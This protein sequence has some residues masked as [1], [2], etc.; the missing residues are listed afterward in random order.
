MGIDYFNNNVK[1]EDLAPGAEYSFYNVNT[2]AAATLTIKTGSGFLGG[3]TINSHTAGII[4]ITDGT[5]FAAGNLMHSSLTFAAG[6]RSIDFRGERFT[7]GL[8][9]SIGGSAFVTV[10]YK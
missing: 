3:I 6:E 10:Q 7:T 9:I 8:T 1:N 2:G 5:T 4:A